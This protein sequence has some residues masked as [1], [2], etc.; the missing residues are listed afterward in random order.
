M[1]KRLTGAM[2]WHSARATIH[3]MDVF[4]EIMADI[5]AQGPDHIALT[6]DLVNVGYAPEFPQALAIAAALGGPEMVSIVPGNHDTYVR[7]SLPAMERSFRSFMLDDG[8]DGAVRFPYL[9][10]RGDVALIG[11]NSGVPTLPFLATG[12]VGHEQRKRLASLLAETRRQG[13][14]RVVMIHHPPL[15]AASRFGRGLTDSQAFMALIAEHGAEL[16]IHG[17]NHR[18]S[19]HLVGS[20]TG[21]VPIIGVA[22]ASAV[23]GTP[24][25]QAEY[26]LI[27]IDAENRT[28]DLTR[29][30]FR[31]GEAGIQTLD[32]LTFGP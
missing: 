6:G 21:P 26:H 20:K 24:H 30:G 17:H 12:R 4:N 1:N 19:R 16:I 15:K 5:V 14:F 3:N 29:R 11:V 25:H 32:T 2:N 9:R 10:R 18:F 27:R 7:E 23:P 31:P 28:F 8:A 13:L 22:S